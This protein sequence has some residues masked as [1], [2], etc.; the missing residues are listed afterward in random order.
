MDSLRKKNVN[1]YLCGKDSPLILFKAKDF[2]SKTEDLFS[3]VKCKVCGLIYLNPRPSKD[4]MEFYYPKEYWWKD[5]N[6][7]KRTLNRIIGRLEDEYRS[8]VIR[9]HMAFLKTILRRRGLWRPLGVKL[10]DIGCGTGLFLNMCKKWGLQGFGIDQSQ[11]AVNHA[12]RMYG[13]NCKVGT[14][15]EGL[16]P[17]GHFDVITMFHV[18]E[19]LPNPLETLKLVGDFLKDEGDIIIQVPNVDSIQFQLLKIRWLGLHI[20][21][22]LVNYSFSTLRKMLEMVGLQIVKVKFFSL[23]DSTPLLISSL[24]PMLD[25]FLL[26]V[27]HA[28][29]IKLIFS[30]FIYLF[31]VML[32]TPL[33]YL[34]S[35]LHRGAVILVHVKKNSGMMTQ[36]MNDYTDPKK[37]SHCSYD[38]A[39]YLCSDS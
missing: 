15:T 38:R 14:I 33:V 4:M 26:R 25:P 28:K 23:R 10:L 27:N 32:F 37:Y 17:K 29:T 36:I 20:P 12:N 9:D 13:V 22:H 31:L 39:S 35:L 1:C 11:E 3:I 30:Q 2:F 16:F 34:E 8:V 18:L 21:R 7:H 5:E 24:L 19:H 6:V